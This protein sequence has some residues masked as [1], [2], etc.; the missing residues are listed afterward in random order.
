MRDATKATSSIPRSDTRGGRRTSRECLLPRLLPNSVTRAGTKTDKEQFSGAKTGTTRHGHLGKRR[1]K[2]RLRLQDRPIVKAPCVPGPKT[3]CPARRR[4]CIP[5]QAWFEEHIR[6]DR[7]C[8][9]RKRLLRGLQRAVMTVSKGGFVKHRITPF[10]PK[11]I[12]RGSGAAARTP[13]LKQRR[14]RK[15]PAAGRLSLT[16]CPHIAREIP[17]LFLHTSGRWTSARRS[18]PCDAG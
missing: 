1:P 16:N 4:A 17:R 8:V 11:A 9:D 14:R 3:D 5:E 10:G 12:A 6:S 13:R 15:T 18:V 2:F 7:R